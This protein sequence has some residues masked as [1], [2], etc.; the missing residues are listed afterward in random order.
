MKEFRILIKQ[1]DHLIKRVELMT[2]NQI[3]KSV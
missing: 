3:I 2:L 1:L